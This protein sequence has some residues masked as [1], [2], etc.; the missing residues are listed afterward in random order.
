MLVQINDIKVKRRIRK[1]MGDITALAD[2]MK[3]FG[4]I[5]PILITKNNVLIA[6][7]RRLEAARNLGWST[8]NAVVAEIPDELSKLEYELEENI[9]RRNFTPTETNE[10]AKRI[11]RLRNPSL[12]R[13]II[14]AIAG[15]F[16]RL[17]R[18]E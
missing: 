18:I 3:R 7:G 11:Y 6:G 1:D 4:Q 5:S 15:F 9:Q 14:A 10:A 8:I 16:R 17:F 12:F 13:R 2:R